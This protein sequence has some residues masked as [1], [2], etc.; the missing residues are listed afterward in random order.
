MPATQR[1]ETEIV[2]GPAGPS[3]DEQVPRVPSV[4]VIGRISTG[5]KESAAEGGPGTTFLI[6]TDWSRDTYQVS[7][8]G[9]KVVRTLG[10]RVVDDPSAYTV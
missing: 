6:H 8:R 4:N 1:N 7:Q 9:L 3:Q 5:G 10:I 2:P